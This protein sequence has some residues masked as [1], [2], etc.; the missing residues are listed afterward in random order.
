VPILPLENRFPR[1]NLDQPPPP[2]GSI[3]LGGA[4]DR[5]GKKRARRR[6]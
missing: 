5:L 3:V 2:V 1:A 4:E 6:R